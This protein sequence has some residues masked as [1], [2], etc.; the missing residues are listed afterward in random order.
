MKAAAVAFVGAISCLVATTAGSGSAHAKVSAAEAAR[1]DQDLTPMGAERA[2]N[3]EGTIPAWTGGLTKPP[4]GFKPGEHYTTPFPDDKPLF[5]ITGQNAEQYKAHLTP[6]QMAL[7]KLYSTY[8]MPVYQ[9][10]R[11]CALPERLYE[12]NRRNALTATMTADDN[13]LNDALL[14]NPFPIPKSGV[15][16]IWNHRLRYRGFKFRRYFASAAV[17]RDGSYTLFKNEDFGI[18]H[19]NGPGLKE[20]GDVTDIKQLNNIGISYINI[21]TSPARLAGSV[22]LVHDTINAKEMPRQAWVYNPGTRRILRAPELAYDNPLYN[23]DGL[24]TTDQFDMYNGATDRYTFEL[25]PKREI[26][27]GYNNYA[28][29]A[30]YKELLTPSTLNP[31]FGRYELHRTW[32]VD[33]KLKEGASHIFGRRV[34]YL[35]EDSWNIAQVDIYDKRGELYR[36]QEG[37]ISNAYELPLCSSAL[38]VTYDLQ[39]GRYIVFALKNEEKWF[40]LNATDVDPGQFTPDAVRRLGTR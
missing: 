29:N 25:K 1:L 34:F 33:S 12:A 13:G 3:A 10:R 31:E 30:T 18:L 40:N 9:T 39:S 11:T 7:L 19:Y 14:G 15:E 36:V 38:E 32:V 8:S 16:A 35:D 28:V 4:A 23:T 26:Y 20:I 27:I 37:P 5:T 24:A 22:V 17:N 2:G 21:T 6:G